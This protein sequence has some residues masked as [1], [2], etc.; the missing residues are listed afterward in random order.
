MVNSIII[1]ILKNR[2]VTYFKKSL[3]FLPNLGYVYNFLSEC[4][5]SMNRIEEASNVIE[6]GIKK[7]PEFPLNY[8]TKGT[9]IT[10]TD[11]SK[12][13][14]VNELY[15]KALDIDPSCVA[16]YEK[17]AITN[18]QLM[19]CDDAVKYLN[20]AVKVYILLI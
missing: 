1:I 6:E 7:D 14:E 11:P 19:K 3:D 4:L 20:K 8:L 9:F 15:K 16:T 18:L 5:F 13:D 17:L 12:Q 10:V 2:A